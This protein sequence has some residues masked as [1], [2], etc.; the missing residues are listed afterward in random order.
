VFT[1]PAASVPWIV[2]ENEDEGGPE[3]AEESYQAQNASGEDARRH[4]I[5]KSLIPKEG[6]KSIAFHSLEDIVLC[7]IEDL[8][9]VPVLVLDADDDILQDAVR[10]DNFSL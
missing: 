2:L 10:Q 5:G 3:P 6:W 9:I 7:G 8:W 1:Y 4:Q